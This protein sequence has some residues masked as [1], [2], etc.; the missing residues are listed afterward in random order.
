MNTLKRK[1]TA[2]L[3][4][5]AMLFSL[6]PALPQTAEAAE[7]NVR[8]DYILY[9]YETSSSAE[10]FGHVDVIV[11]DS[12]GNQL[13]ETLQI[14][15][16]YKTY[17]ST[18]SIT[19]LDD[20]YEIEDIQVSDGVVTRK[21]VKPDQS[22]FAWTFSGDSATLTITLCEP[23][24]APEI[25]DPIGYSAVSYHISYNQ[26][27]KMM[28]VNGITD[29]SETTQIKSVQ[30]IWVN[31]FAM[32]GV[33]FSRIDGT[34]GDTYWNL[35]V[36]GT[37]KDDVEPYNIRFIEIAYDN[38]DGE[39]VTKV[40]ASALRFT[41]IKGEAYYRVESNNDDVHAVAFYNESD[42]N[43]ADQYD[44]YAIRFV[45][46]PD[47]NIG[48]ENMPEDPVYNEALTDYKFVNWEIDA[49]YG[50]NGEAFLATTIVDRDMN[51]YAHKVSSSY[52]GGTY[53]RLMNNYD[54]EINQLIDRLVEGYNDKYNANILADQ[55]DES[56]IKVRVYGVNNEYTNEN[57]YSNDWSGTEYYLVHNYDA[58]GVSGG[59]DVNQNTHVGFNEVSSVT[60][61]FSL[62][63]EKDIATIEIPVGNNA[64]DL[65][66]MMK[67]VGAD[68]I[69]Q[70]YVI[71][72]GQVVSGESEDPDP[73]PQPPAAPTEDELNALIDVT[74]DCESNEAHELKTY[75]DLLANSYTPGNVT[76]N[77]NGTYSYSLTVYNGAYV[78]KY[79]NEYV[80]GH[81]ETGETSAVV[82]L[83]NDGN[84]WE[85]ADGLVTMVIPFLVTCDSGSQPV[86]G[87]T[88]S[89]FEKDLIAGA[90]E[91]AAAEKAGV[92]VENYYIPEEAN[93][94]VTIPYDGEV[95]LLYSITVTGS[96]EDGKFVEFFI[97][98]E[99]A[100]LI[101][102]KSDVSTVKDKPGVFNGKLKGENASIT[103]YVSKTF[104]ADQLTE[105]GDKTYLV[106]EASIEV[107]GEG[108][109]E[110][111]EN[112]DEKVPA[113]ES[114]KPDDPTYEDMKEP[115]VNGAVKID[116]INP[117]VQ[118]EDPTYGLIEGSYT[119]PADG[120]V[121]D[122]AN[123]FT[124]TITVSPDKYIET[125]NTNTQ[126]SHTLVDG[127]SA[128]TITYKYDNG[129][130]V[131]ADTTALPLVYEVN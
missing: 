115:V 45:V 93:Q 27:L 88:I 114:E 50:D 41:G 2:I 70:L 81:N 94:T 44:L 25:K 119:L 66:K 86:T 83:V 30:P 109:I 54:G 122:E 67:G 101:D 111:E 91:K 126:S 117:L 82:E 71:Q 102:T 124:Y 129:D 107:K 43:T 28:Y 58:P 29:V 56:T 51:V 78:E 127:Q 59:I 65:A 10:L 34:V 106:N 18:D 32:D 118:H 104:N 35:Q 89:D 120:V 14:D 69:L 49:Y 39:Q 23:Y 105:I 37:T 12:N 90:D 60:V 73:E 1:L 55:I 22:T 76:A 103:F 36:S 13:G 7:G 128:K 24:Q 110:T 123:G 20:N 38:G 131:V 95:T 64:G 100:T 80:D 11:Q 97:T 85:L 116:C 52:S 68:H 63:G 121:G 19:V 61:Y 96:A 74:V 130:W 79:N 62:N 16:Y 48:E 75:P 53:I 108:T 40:P 112:I 125:Y 3:L 15:N 98:D 21:D 33:N 4:T 77:A 87:G 92:D 31:S 84:G 113:V 46:D 72:E 47:Q 99:G 57:Y 6:M 9:E 26:L 5:F 17:V 42:L 8:N